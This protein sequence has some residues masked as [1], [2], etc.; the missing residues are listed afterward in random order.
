[1]NPGGKGANQA[2]AAA[3]LGG[4]VTFVTKTGNDMFGHEA[5]ILLAKEGIDAGYIIVDQV[6][7]SGVA[8]ITVDEHGEN[9]IVVAPGSNGNLTASDINDEV[10]ETDDQDIFLMQLEIP[11]DTVEFVAGKAS[12]KG[13]RVILN[14]APATQLS[15]SLLSCLYLIT[16]NENEAE[17]ITGIKVYDLHSA[18]TAASK[19]RDKGVLNVVITM[20]SSGAYILSEG[21]SKLIPVTPVKAIDT[22]AAG[23]V[24]NGALAV[25]ISEGKGLE[26]AVVFANKAAAISVTRMGAQAS[27]PFRKEIS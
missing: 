8:L 19:L 1:M 11:A 21:L 10:F 22:T 20:G 9:S 13:N 14:P 4:N 18:E 6:N 16:P 26:D 24:F 12:D 25:A 5:G 15:D 23:D 2:V 3:R 27:A 17:L 7:P